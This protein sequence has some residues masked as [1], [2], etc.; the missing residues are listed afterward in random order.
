MKEEEAKLRFHRNSVSKGLS[1]PVESTHFV[2]RG[3]DIIEESEI[4]LQCGRLNFTTH[5][6]PYDNDF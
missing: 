3:Q 1:S 6:M 2:L 4:Q 5:K